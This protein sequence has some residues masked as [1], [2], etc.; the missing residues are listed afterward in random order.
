MEVANKL[1]VEWIQRG[2]IED[3]LYLS[4]LGLTSLP[5]LPNNLQILNCGYNQ[6][7][8]L[9]NLPNNLK[10]LKCNNNDLTRLPDLS[11]TLQELFCGSNKLTRL[12]PLPNTLQQLYCGRNQLTSLPTLPNTLQILDCSNNKL[13]SLP[14][15]PNT[16]LYLVCEYNPINLK[17]IDTKQLPEQFKTY[18]K[19]TFADKLIDINKFNLF[20]KDNIAKCF[21]SNPVNYPINHSN[22]QLWLDKIIQL[23]DP[24]LTQFGYEFTKTLTHIS[25]NEFYDSCCKLS[26][27]ILET[28][29]NL[30]T[31]YLASSRKQI[32]F[33]VD[34]LSKSS[35]WVLM[36]MWKFIAD[37]VDIL[38]YTFDDLY[39]YVD[40]P[41]NS[42]NYYLFYLDDC[43][44]SGNQIIKRFTYTDRKYMYL[45]NIY[46]CCPYMSVNSKNRFVDVQLNVLYTQLIPNF[47]LNSKMIANQLYNDLFLLDQAENI[48]N[49]YFDHKLASGVSTFQGIIA[50][51]LYVKP[52]Y[53]L[54]ESQ[55]YTDGEIYTRKYKMLSEIEPLPLI[56]GC[57]TVYTA[58]KIRYLYD[59]NY[60]LQTSLKSDKNSS[61]LESEGIIL[62]GICPVAFYKTIKYSVSKIED[63]NNIKI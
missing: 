11:N 14:S 37:K 16:L 63:I 13:T 12:P 49:I 44:Y 38:L 23:G 17:N 42:C 18:L 27:S 29:N 6:L 53:K 60:D 58:D 46:I 39:K 19:F 10:I 45:P 61:P 2:D 32:I 21:M 40:I 52:E 20:H 43:S 55:K 9:P 28:I 34:I 22:V 31:S 50:F 3:E 56:K 41:N 35:F 59:G 7:T 47:Q 4:N 25:F 24:V 51:G 5:Q 1:I 30:N 26:F 48:C 15:L 33:Y 36:L 62:K 57:E 54:I 8:N